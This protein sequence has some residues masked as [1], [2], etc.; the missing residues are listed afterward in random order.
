MSLSKIINRKPGQSNFTGQMHQ[1]DAETLKKLEQA[2]ATNNPKLYN[3]NNPGQLLANQPDQA[4]MDTMFA[5]MDPFVLVKLDHEASKYWDERSAPADN[6]SELKELALENELTP[7]FTFLLEMLTPRLPT[8]F[9][10]LLPDRILQNFKIRG[11]RGPLNPKHK[12]AP[13][14]DWNHNQRDHRDRR[15]QGEHR[16]DQMDYRRDHRDR[17]DQRDRGDHRERRDQLDHRDQGYNQRNMQRDSH[18]SHNTH[19]E[20]RNDFNTNSGR[21]DGNARWMPPSQ[22]QSQ[23]QT[24]EKP[25]SEDKISRIY[26]SYLENIEKNAGQRTLT[27]N[28]LSKPLFLL[29]SRFNFIWKYYQAFSSKSHTPYILSEVIFKDL[30]Y[31]YLNQA[32]F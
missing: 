10:E 27:A 29:I 25:E 14:G 23:P 6:T 24:Q 7:Q 9:Y 4:Q 5:N 22:E 19:R 13:P 21:M 32:N 3:P 16:R 1:I 20:T 26:N 8:R 11:V 2:D 31:K 28:Y 18:N 15:D 17:R 12:P 30:K